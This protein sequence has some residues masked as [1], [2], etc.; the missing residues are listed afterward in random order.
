MTRAGF[1]GSWS[2]LLNEGSIGL[3]RGEVIARTQ[4]SLFLLN[5]MGFLKNRDILD[6]ARRRVFLD[7]DPGFGQMWRELGLADVFAGHDCFV[8]I[9]EN[10][11]K[12]G[13]LIPT[14]GLHWL[15]TRQP[16]VLSEWPQQTGNGSRFT[17]VARWRSDNAPVM[18]KEH[19]YGL[20]VHE[21][22]KFLS[23]PKL[24]DESLELAL[25]ID[26]AETRDLDLLST[27]GWRLTNPRGDVSQMAGYRSYL[28]S[29][30]GEFLV[31]KNMYVDTRS[32]WFSDRSACYLASGR[33]VIAQD[34]S[35]HG[36][37]PL[38]EGLLAYE[39]LDDAV[40][41]V[42]AI[43]EDYP[44]HSRRAREIAEEYFDS[45]KVLVRL[46]EGITH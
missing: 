43:G 2:L 17:S 11:G 42:H 22:R 9:A 32:G 3:S 30:R 41:A 36:L 34:T 23:L 13:C 31:A 45:D 6:A 44:R 7:I 39:T 4:T 37:Y 28:Q 26:P 15:T 40:A 27:N 14:C 8:T 18:Y 10:M 19:A 25:E 21:F 29:S 1:D 20:R 46:I 5:V 38:G 35:L 12:P 16:V 33:P 24:V